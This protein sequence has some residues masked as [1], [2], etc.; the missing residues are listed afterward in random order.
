M[1]CTYGKRAGS[2]PNHR[3]A[4]PRKGNNEPLLRPKGSADS[5]RVGESTDSHSET[6]SKVPPDCTVNF[7][8]MAQRKCITSAISEFMYTAGRVESKHDGIA[9]TSPPAGTNRQRTR[10]RAHFLPSSPT[11]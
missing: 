2:T 4:F 8:P 6:A 7:P 3:R 10:V 9:Y 5:D 11:E 1:F